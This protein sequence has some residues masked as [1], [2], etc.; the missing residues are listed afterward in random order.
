MATTTAVPGV[1]TASPW[2]SLA[3]IGV[4]SSPLSRHD[5]PFNGRSAALPLSLRQADLRHSY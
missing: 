2:V 3:P 5:V 4:R 1:P